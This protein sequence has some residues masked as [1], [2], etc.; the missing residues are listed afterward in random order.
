MIKNSP[1]K[2][3]INLRERICVNKRLSQINKYYYNFHQ[4]Q[5]QA[6]AIGKTKQMAVKD[7]ELFNIKTYVETRKN[8]LENIDAIHLNNNVHSEN[9]KLSQKSM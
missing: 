2:N 5:Q 9:K 4:F 7:E 1:Y 3:L 6:Q 8:P